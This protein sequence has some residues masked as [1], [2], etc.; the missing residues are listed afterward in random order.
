MGPVNFRVR[1]PGKQQGEQIYHINLL[2]RWVEP[3]NQLPAFA[4]KEP[5]VVDLGTQLSAAQ[6]KELEALVSS[7]S[8]VFSETLG[9]TDV[10]SY[11][12]HNPPDT[13]IRQWPYRVPEV[14]RQAIEEEAQWM[15]H[16]GVIKES[17]SPWSNPIV[18]VPKKDG[19]Y[20]FCNDFRKLNEVS[21][22]NSYPMP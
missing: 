1:Q 5:A 9:Q 13:I 8:D 19:T 20:R 6:K 18:M 12:I 14:R 7:F 16:L 21:Q 2:K 3:A 11:E 15:L 22:F 17:Q 4:I 10:L